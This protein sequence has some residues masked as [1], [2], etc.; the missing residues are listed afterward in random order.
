LTID[1]RIAIHGGFNGEGVL[2]QNSRIPLKTQG[3]EIPPVT[4]Q[5]Y[6]QNGQLA[7]AFSRGRERSL[8]TLRLKASWLQC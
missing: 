1:P 5:K 8:T 7:T 4:V 6:V 3:S 2:V